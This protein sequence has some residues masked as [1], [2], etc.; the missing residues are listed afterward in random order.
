M[1]SWKGKENIFSN[2]LISWY[3]FSVWRSLLTQGDGDI[4]ALG[5]RHGL[6]DH[7]ARLP[8][9]QV[10]VLH[11]GLPLLVVATLPGQLPALI[12]WLLNWHFLAHICWDA[13]IR[14]FNKILENYK[15]VYL[16]VVGPSNCTFILRYTVTFVFQLTFP[17]TDHL[18]FLY[19]DLDLVIFALPDI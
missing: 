5:D 9:L 4:A 17:F 10:A 7:G 14:K 3:V 12:N 2:L 15:Y 16:T 6:R 11:R 1:N 18:Q 8:G 19:K 13:L